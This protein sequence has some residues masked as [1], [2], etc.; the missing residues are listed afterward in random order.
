MAI[1]V[2]IVQVKDYVSKSNLPVCDYVINPYV[3]CTFGCRYCYAM[4]MKR[5]TNHDEPWGSF[6][7][8]KECDKPVSVRRLTGKKVLLSSV[9][10]CYNQFEEKY[11]ITRYILEQ[12]LSID[13]NVEITTKSKLILRDLELLKQFKSLHI[14]VSLNTLD[15]NFR[16][17]MDKA[18]TIHDRLLTLY[19]LRESGIDAALFISPIFPGI[20]DFRAIIEASKTFVDEYWFENLNLRAGYK[21]QIL[22]YIAQKHPGLTG[23][24]DDIYNKKQ[25]DYWF[26]LSR[27]IEDYCNGNKI[28]FTNYFYHEKLVQA[29]KAGAPLL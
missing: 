22:S 6:I 23:L 25:L 5:F 24:Y 13:C 10:D 27:E 8:V 1:A 7:D 19:L 21:K 4:F 2:N 28:R 18:S 26:D 29:K 15:E 12:L 20:T 11:W 14:A 17:D 9:T 16:H 3:G